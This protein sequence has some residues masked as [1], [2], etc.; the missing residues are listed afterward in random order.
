MRKDVITVS[1]YTTIKQLKEIMKTN[2]ISGVPVLESGGLIGVASIEDL[3]KALEA[4]ELDVPVSQRMTRKLITV[5]EKES[6]IEA[7]KKFSQFHVGRL[8][9]VN[10]QGDLTGILTGSDITR[11]LLEA[12]SLTYHDE[13]IKRDPPMNYQEYI[14]SDRTSLTL[15]YHIKEKDFKSGGSASSKIK[16][17]FEQL[18]ISPQILRRVAICAYEAEMNLIIHADAGG[19]LITEIQPDL[20]HMTVTD[21]GPGIIDVER[22]MAPGF[23]TAP[24]RIQELGFGAGMGLANILKCADSFTIESKPGTGTQLDIQIKI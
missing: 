18:G 20:I 1:P 16:K 6:I 10:E 24:T 5:M 7:I 12:I 4:G 11:G 2:R 23:S 21:H 3:I 17:A 22:A 8:L 13:E 14:V 15:R 9:V 19:E